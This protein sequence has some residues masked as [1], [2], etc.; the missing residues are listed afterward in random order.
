VKVHTQTRPACRGKR[1]VAVYVHRQ[2]SNRD[3]GSWAHV[4]Q[5]ELCPECEGTGRVV[6]MDAG[7]VP[8]RENKEVQP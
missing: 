8:A 6:V 7:A 5:F 3:G 4:R 2:V 1:K